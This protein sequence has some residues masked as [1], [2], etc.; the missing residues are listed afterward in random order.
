MADIENHTTIIGVVYELFDFA[1]FI[2]HAIWLA[3]V[4]MRQHV[5]FTHGL[6]NVF[7][8]RRISAHMNHDWQ[9]A[10]QSSVRF[11]CQ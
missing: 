11:S 2:N 6:H 7:K 5:T 3:V 9:V 1:M 4:S 8:F 10:Q